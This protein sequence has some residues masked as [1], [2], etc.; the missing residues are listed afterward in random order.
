MSFLGSIAGPLRRV[1]A[2]YADE[3]TVPVLLPCAGNFTVGAALRSGGAS[4]ASRAAASP[5]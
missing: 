3:I 5:S 4:A 1:L 2:A